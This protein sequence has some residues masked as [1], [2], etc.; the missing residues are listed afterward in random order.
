MSCVT[1]RD[2]K[3]SADS[4]QA[5]ER[6]RN[7]IESGKLLMGM[8]PAGVMATIFLGNKPLHAAYNVSNTD[9]AALTE[10]LMGVPTI[11]RRAVYN[12]ASM[13]YLSTTGKEA[14]FWRGIAEGCSIN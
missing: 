8:L 9:F 3:F 6:I 12:D 4:Q 13:M 2:V 14:A 7:R 1:V 10:A 5:I 11:V